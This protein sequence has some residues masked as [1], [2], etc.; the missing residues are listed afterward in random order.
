[1]ALLGVA[2]ELEAVLDSLA[3]TDVEMHAALQTEFLLGIACN[4][5]RQLDFLAMEILAR[6]L[7]QSVELTLY[8]VV[9]TWIAIAEVHCR[10]PHLE[11]EVP[12]A[13]TVI[14]ER[15]FAVIKD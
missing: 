14:K 1:L 2:D 12:A 11:I 7:R 13:F 10:V 8:G 4:H 9:E 5:R 6:D 3:A 15:T